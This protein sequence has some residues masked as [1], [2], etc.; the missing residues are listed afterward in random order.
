MEETAITFSEALQVMFTGLFLSFFTSFFAWKKGF[1]RL[2]EGSE[3]STDKTTPKLPLFAVL[4][5]F[6]IFLALSILIVPLIFVVGLSLYE[7]SVAISPQTVVLM[8]SVS[9]VINFIALLIFYFCLNQ[10]N[11][12][13]IKGEY[14]GPTTSFRKTLSDISIGVLT[15]F[16]S[17]PV[18]MVAGKVVYMI[19]YSFGFEVTPNQVAVSQVQISL[20][21]PYLFSFIAL[22]VALLVP[23]VEEFLF[24]GCLQT[25][26]RGKIGV[27]KAILLTSIV[28][29]SFHFSTSQGLGNIELLVSLMI[30][31]C[32]L[33][34]I[35]E[36]QRS[37][38]AS[39][40]LHAFFNAV[41]VIMILFSTP[42]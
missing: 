41:T 24:R 33:G 29:S 35:Y 8:S 3:D 15:W 40:S 25:W 10:N 5:P 31:S 14:F 20:E 1:Y 16:I 30:L 12:N 36:K 38:L 39:I 18:V 19:L 32:F 2:S 42:Y 28:F 4:I 34:F 11:R 6:A 9:I 21:S 17:F 23:F 13:L 7:R 26:M 37:L 22:D 27:N